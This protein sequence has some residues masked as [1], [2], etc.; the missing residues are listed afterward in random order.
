MAMEMAFDGGSLSRLSG[1]KW[2]SYLNK[3]GQWTFEDSPGETSN[4][5]WNFMR[6]YQILYYYRM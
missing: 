3:D 4:L 5:R 6:S 2:K 1:F